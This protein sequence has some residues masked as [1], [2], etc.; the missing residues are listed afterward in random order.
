[1]VLDVQRRECDL[2]E[3]RVELAFESESLRT[4]CESSADA[5]SELG[6]DVAEA[7]QRRLADLR[8]ATVAS[9]LVA[10]EPRIDDQSI[11]V[12]KLGDR[13]RMILAP[14]HIETRVDSDG[15]VEWSRVRRMKVLAIERDD[16]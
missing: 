6:A 7:L 13:Y 12:F 9:D 4:V 8:A 11:I 16:G 2:R 1:M 5:E 10:G 3:V 14:N 15:G